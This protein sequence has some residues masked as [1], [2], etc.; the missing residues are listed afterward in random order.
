MHMW[1]Q[2]IPKA[3]DAMFPAR[4]SHDALDLLASVDKLHPSLWSRV[5]MLDWIGE[6]VPTSSS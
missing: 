6:G 1:G 2:M 5:L 4:I 3:G